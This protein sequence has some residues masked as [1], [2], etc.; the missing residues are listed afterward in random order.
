MGRQ[1]VRQPDGLF[2]VWSSNVDDWVIYDA[3]ADELIEHFADQAAVEAR[4]RLSVMIEAVEAGEPE[5]VYY[6]FAL[7]F[8]AAQ[9]HRRHVHGDAPWPPPRDVVDL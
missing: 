1:I 9:E 3:T 2:A 8:E 7:T 5:R 4:R 6:Q